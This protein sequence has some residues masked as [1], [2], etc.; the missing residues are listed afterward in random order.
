MPPPDGRPDRIDRLARTPGAT[1]ITAENWHAVR[2]ALVDAGDRFERLMRAVPPRTMA[3]A[4]WTAADTAAH[5]TAIAWSNTSRIVSDET[6]LP[7]DGEDEL[8]RSTTVYNIHEGINDALQNSYTERDPDAVLARLRS[9]ITQMLDLTADADPSRTVSWL[10]ESR[11]PLAG[12]F[13]HLT[14]ELLVHGRDIAR[15]GRIRGWELPPEYAALFFELFMVEICRNGLGR[16]LDGGPPVPDR[17]IA[18]EF[19]SAYTRPVTIAM[20]RGQVRI[21]EPS[22]DNDIRL[23]FKPAALSL[24]LFHR[25]TPVT[26]A[27]TG[28]VRVWG[29][30][31]WL[32]PAFMRKVR[33]P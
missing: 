30:R 32:L 29:R 27:M 14:N 2:S 26:T 18:V 17:R 22:P 11:L 23:F 7:F 12:L 24:M 25:H 10:G 28:G 9:S 21:E 1:R 33:L 8:L 16:V 5:V 15:A 31:P 19:R 13:A 6:P 3:T 20:E 4:D